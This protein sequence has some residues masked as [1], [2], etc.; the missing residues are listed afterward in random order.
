LRP[1]RIKQLRTCDEHDTGAG[2]GKHPATGARIL[3]HVMLAAFDRAKRYGID[4][5]PRLKARL[6]DEK[7]S[8]FAQFRHSLTPERQSGSFEPFKS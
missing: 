2:Q 5:Q 3:R 8:D 7:P 4:H 6:D 1:Y